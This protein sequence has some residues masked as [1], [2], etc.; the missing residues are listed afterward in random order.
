M[1]TNSFI[2]IAGVGLRTEQ[3][4][5][6]AGLMSWESFNGELPIRLSTR[7]RNKLQTGID[8]S[9][10]YLQDQNPSYFSQ[11]MPGNQIWRLFNE[12]RDSTAYVDIET[13]GLDR[14]SHKITTIALYGGQSIKTYVQGQN[15]NEFSE[16]ISNY[17][18]IVTYNGKCFDVPFIEKH[19]NL[20][21]DMVHI[22]LR[23]IMQSL[24]FR[25]GLKGCER[26]L[27]IERGNLDGVD[28][29]MAVQLWEK[30]SQSGSQKIL[31]TL[32]SYNVQDAVVLEQLLT[33]AYNLKLKTTPFGDSNW[34][35]DT[36][37]PVN[38]YRADVETIENLKQE[39]GYV[40]YR[41]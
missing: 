17:K 1:L 31:D 22:D 11:R 5:W 24:G 40:Y 19:L 15:M 8:E 14:F 23:W 41:Y 16:D 29:Y 27:G 6:D 12:F 21:I 7:R 30:Y 28:G 26:Q 33:T 32:L 38:P 36:V 34:L 3:M 18:V 2:H 9:L 4:L 35:A 10:E 20:R 13:T 39:G 25:G 37:V